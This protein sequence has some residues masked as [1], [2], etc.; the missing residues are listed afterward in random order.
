MTETALRAKLK[1]PAGIGAS[2]PR[3]ILIRVRA[4]PRV[5]LF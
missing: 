4:G 1:T 2:S 5:I 3:V